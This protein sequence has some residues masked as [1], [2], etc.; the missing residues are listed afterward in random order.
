LAPGEFLNLQGL[1]K[2]ITEFKK[3]SREVTDEIER[4]VDEPPPPPPVSKATTPAPGASA[5]KH[6]STSAVPKA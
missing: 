6:L 2:G 3:A 1:G 4:A 5:E